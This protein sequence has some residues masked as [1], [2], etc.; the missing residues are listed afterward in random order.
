M[1][2][3][4]CENNGFCTSGCSNKQICNKQRILLLIYGVV[5]DYGENKIYPDEYMNEIGI[6][7]QRLIDETCHQGGSQTGFFKPRKIEIVA[8]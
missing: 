3:H 6:L 4:L 5:V 8:V 2:I 1:L 7:R